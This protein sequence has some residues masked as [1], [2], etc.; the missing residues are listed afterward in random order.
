MR[1]KIVFLLFRSVKKVSGHRL[2]HSPFD[3][4]GSVRPSE[5]VRPF[6][7]DLFSSRGHLKVRNPDPAGRRER[8]S[9]RKGQS[10]GDAAQRSAGSHS[11]AASPDRDAGEDDGVEAV[12]H[13]VVLTAEFS[14][15]HCQS[16]LND[17][18]QSNT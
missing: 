3:S 7:D 11:E 5:R 16:I 2:H 12:P 6:V 13:Q 10:P 1:L 17:K 8:I 15:F 4:P 9:P 14:A 18:N